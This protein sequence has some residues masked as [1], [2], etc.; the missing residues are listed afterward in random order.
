MDPVN[1]RA[2]APYID[3][4]QVADG[5]LY[6]DR[7]DSPRQAFWEATVLGEATH[8]LLI[9]A[10][11]SG[12][13]SE[14]LRLAREVAVH[15]DPPI[16]ALLRLQDQCNPEALSPAQVLFLIGVMAL[17]VHDPGRTRTRL[18]ADLRSAY[19]QIVHPSGTA[20]VDVSDLI[21]R[22]AL[23]LAGPA[24]KLAPA[25][26]MALGA[27]GTLLK[28]VHKSPTIALPGRGRSLA[29]NDPAVTRLADAVNACI[30]A[31]RSAYA[32]APLMLFVD[33]LDKV[34]MT[35][36]ESMFGS[37]I[38]ARPNCTVIYTAPLTLRYSLLGTAS[39]PWF[40]T[41]TLGN[42][43]VFT[44]DPDG[45]RDPTGFAAMRG[46]L[47]R[48]IHAAG[49]AA[50]QVFE[51]GLAEGGL[52]DRLIEA[53]GGITRTFI[54]LCDAA[55]RRGLV[56][57]HAQ[58]PRLGEQEVDSVIRDFEQRTV[59]RLRPEHYEPLLDCWE[60]RARPSGAHGDELLFGNLVH[61]YANDWPWYRPTPLVLRFLR[62]RFPERGPTGA[63][64]QG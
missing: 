10:T 56:G 41:L 26:G 23:Y 3:P 53:S 35:Q 40:K 55:L 63:Q 19:L 6:V 54:L 15:E 17:R 27:S 4:K 16:I 24:T 13:S 32:R 62:E 18:L 37:D 64:S 60:S 9:G 36:T 1:A 11:G 48:R 34:D 59:T 28:A 14:L 12:K 46:L 49:L 42:F 21:G 5:E 31:A 44:H 7:V 39:D 51:D 58:R 8:C 25:A 45:Q 22:L 57:N 2:L 29:A 50:E 20:E 30:D 38:L 61:C 47:D 52:V 33:G 43:R